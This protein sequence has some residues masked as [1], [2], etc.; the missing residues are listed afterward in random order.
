MTRK[1]AKMAEHKPHPK[2][3]KCDRCRTRWA[4]VLTGHHT[5]PGGYLHLCDVC[6]GVNNPG[7]AA[8]EPPV[9]SFAEGT[10]LQ[11]INEPYRGRRGIGP[12]PVLVTIW[13]KYKPK[14]G[15]EED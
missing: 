3:V 9:Y 12:S 2:A 7:L 4:T 5:L 8:E 15:K 10:P 13:P 6:A 14:A 1:G 11:D